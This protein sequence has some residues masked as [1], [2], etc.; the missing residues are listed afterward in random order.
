VSDHDAMFEALHWAQRD[1]ETLRAA[2][3]RD[4][5]GLRDERDSLH[6]HAN[7]VM[8]TNTEFLV[9]LT[10]AVERRQRAEALISWIDGMC[11]DEADHMDI[12]AA[13]NRY[14]ENTK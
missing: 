14:R 5:Q 13:I 11:V 2:F 1:V 8:A 6:A 7:A 10:V 4:L 12:R 3:Q 9:A